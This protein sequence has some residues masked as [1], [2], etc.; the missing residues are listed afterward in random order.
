MVFYK[1][2][3]NFPAD[4]GLVAIGRSLGVGEANW[5]QLVARVATWPSLFHRYTT[6]PAHDTPWEAVR[7]RRNI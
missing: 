6:Y 4:E 3:Y 5:T 1:Y 2:L 7:A